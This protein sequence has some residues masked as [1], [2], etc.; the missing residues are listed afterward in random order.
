MFLFI[1]ILLRWPFSRRVRGGLEARARREGRREMR[2][3]VT[4]GRAREEKSGAAMMA[5]AIN[6]NMNTNINI[7]MTINITTKI[8]FIDLAIIAAK[9]ERGAA[10]RG[11]QLLNRDQRLVS[12]KG[13]C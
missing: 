1:Y 4:R 6:T 2:H 7:N 9:E 3:P 8:M 10:C 5:D 12:N 11:L 13:L